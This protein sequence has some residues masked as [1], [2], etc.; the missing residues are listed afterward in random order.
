MHLARSGEV[1][2]A[3]CQGNELQLLWLLRIFKFLILPGVRHNSA[4][5]SFL[6]G[7]SSPEATHFSPQT[8]S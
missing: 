5:S 4:V 8:R 3:V 7:N 1:H 6:M 2:L